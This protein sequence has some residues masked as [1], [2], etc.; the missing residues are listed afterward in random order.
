MTRIAVIVEEPMWRKL[1]KDFPAELRRAARAAMDAEAARSGTLT[2][3][4][5]DDAKL[6]GLHGQFRKKNKP[7]NVLSFPATEDGYLGDV[8]IAY[9][10]TAREVCDSGKSIH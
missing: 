1:G 9:G 10:V 7:T 4:L 5:A 3:V 8:A 6:E 2:I